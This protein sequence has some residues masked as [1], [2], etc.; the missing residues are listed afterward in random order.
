MKHL[1]LFV[2]LFA[3]MFLILAG[4]SCQQSGAAGSAKLRGA[5]HA[6]DGGTGLYIISGGKRYHIESQQDLS[7]KVGEMVTLNGT[8]DQK[9][10]SYTITVNALD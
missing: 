9:D 8:I 6:E 7:S 5:I 2:C 10:G 3:L 4:T 1:K